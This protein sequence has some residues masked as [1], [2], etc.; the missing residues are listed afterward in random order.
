MNALNT[1]Q[2]RWT[3]LSLVIF[4]LDQIS[5]WLTTKYLIIGV[6]LT[7]LPFFNLYRSH[8]L[9]ASFGFLSLAG[10][11][12]RWLFLATAL[13]ISLI[14]ISMLY[15]MAKNQ[16]WSACA[17]ALILGGA[18]GNFYDRLTLGYVI[19][20]FDFHLGNWHFATFNVA[21]SAICVGVLMWI[22]GSLFNKNSD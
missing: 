7:L 5:K 11:W 8:N 2:L 3:W 18:I 19:D 16:N 22:L 4:I 17:M 15:R 1:N 6:P 14:I 20:F 21:D 10:G 13:V 12:Q 9:G